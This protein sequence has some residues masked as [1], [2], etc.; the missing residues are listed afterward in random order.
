MLLYRSALSCRVRIAPALNKGALEPSLIRLSRGVLS[1]VRSII[2]AYSLG[3][4]LD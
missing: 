2:G 4:D 3:S 1:D